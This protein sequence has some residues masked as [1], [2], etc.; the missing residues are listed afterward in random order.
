MTLAFLFAR[1]AC[2][3]KLS[4]EIF[5]VALVFLPG[6]EN[7][8]GVS[9]HSMRCGRN[10]FCLRMRVSYIETN[11]SRIRACLQL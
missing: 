5:C 7:R 10:C 8:H 1:A 4:R 9:W 2:L 3:G 11:R 6:P